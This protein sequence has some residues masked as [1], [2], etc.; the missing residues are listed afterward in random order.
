[1]NKTTVAQQDKATGLLLSRRGILQR[2]CACGSYTL[3]G[4]ECAECAKKKTSLQRKLAIGASNDSLEREADRVA[5]QVLA[6][7][8]SNAHRSAPLRIQRHAEQTVGATDNTPDSVDRAL[9]GSGKPLEPV[10]RQDM[11]QRFGHDFSRVRVH[12]DGAAE[13]SARD[14]N[15]RAYTV[16]RNVVFA[17]GQFAPETHQGRRLLAHELTHVVQQHQWQGEILQKQ[18]DDVMDTDEVT[19]VPVEEEPDQIADEKP[20]AMKGKTKA[21]KKKPKK[22]PKSMYAHYFG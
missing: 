16:G 18:A 6:S 20:Q 19:E 4:G 14:V 8:G 21:T 12:S 22:E 5:D 9:A 1:M 3:V 13:Q 15:A 10:L 2:K 11:E 17:A 7:T